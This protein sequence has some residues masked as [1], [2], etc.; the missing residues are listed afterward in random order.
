MNT[1]ANTTYNHA[2]ENYSVHERIIHF[3]TPYHTIDSTSCAAVEMALLIH[4]GTQVTDSPQ[5]DG[6]TRDDMMLQNYLAVVESLPIDKVRPGSLQDAM[7]MKIRLHGSK[8]D[9]NSPRVW[10]R[11]KDIRSDL[12]TNYLISDKFTTDTLSKYIVRKTQVHRL[13]T[14]YIC[15]ECLSFSG[16]CISSAAAHD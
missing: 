15:A 14:D 8:K 1:P 10:D 9:I 6:E 5:T 2:A 13:C 7:A 11:F 4:A 16:V 3:L 12:R